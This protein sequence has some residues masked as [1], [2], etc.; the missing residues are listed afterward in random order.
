MKRPRLVLSEAA[1]VDILEQ[2]QW[3]HEQSGPA[4]AKRW[5]KAVADVLLGVVKNPGKGA[6]CQFRHPDLRGVKRLPILGF[7][8]HLLFYKFLASEIFVLRIVHGAR[9]LENLL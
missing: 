6:E 2:A 4:L 8:R 9:D 5:E 1:V 7:S 3:Y